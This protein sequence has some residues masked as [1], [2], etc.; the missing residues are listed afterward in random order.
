MPLGNHGIGT[1]PELCIQLLEVEIPCYHVMHAAEIVVEVC[2]D[3]HPAG[4][5]SRM[6]GYHYSELEPAPVILC[7]Y[8]RTRKRNMPG[9]F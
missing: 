8:Q 1:V 9:C 3:G 5:E 6:R 2:K 7:E 4:T